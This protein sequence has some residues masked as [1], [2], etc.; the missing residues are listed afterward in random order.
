MPRSRLLLTLTALAFGWITEAQAQAL[1][2][3]DLLRCQELLEQLDPAFEPTD[4]Q[5]RCLGLLAELG[6]QP[7]IGPYRG[8][9]DR[10]NDNNPPAFGRPS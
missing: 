9:F 5:A 2:E 4:E 8:G 3:E 7:A 10:W 6:V 1:S